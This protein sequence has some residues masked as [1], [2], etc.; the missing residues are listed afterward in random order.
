MKKI[1]HANGNEKE[2]GIATFV[3]HKIDFKINITKDKGYLIMI[4]RSVQEENIPFLKCSTHRGAP[5]YKTNI[6]RHKGRK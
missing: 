6:N 3:S 5:I 1:S 2:A 4:K